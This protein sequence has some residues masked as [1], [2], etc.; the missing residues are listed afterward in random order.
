LSST[1]DILLAED[2]EHIARLVSFKL[3]KDGYRVEIARNGQ[4]ALERLE[5]G[6]WRLLILDVMMPIV[7]GY[8]VLKAARASPRTAELPVLMLTAKAQPGGPETEGVKGLHYLKKPFDPSQLSEVVRAI[9]GKAG[10]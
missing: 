6:D 7:D 3:G 8:A 1:I 5:R 4:E 9:V 2:E 10:P